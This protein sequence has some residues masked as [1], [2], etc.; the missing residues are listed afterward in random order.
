MEDMS[1]EEEDQGMMENPQSEDENHT[2][3]NRKVIFAQDA[4]KSLEN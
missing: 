1:S 4:S 3:S 2:T